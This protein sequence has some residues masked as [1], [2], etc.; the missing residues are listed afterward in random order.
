LAVP[1][2]V[3]DRLAA[4]WD[5]LETRGLNPDDL[6][7]LE[8]PLEGPALV[9]GAGFGIVVEALAASG[10]APVYGLDHSTTMARAARDRR[11]IEVLAGT[12]VALPFRN[13][14]FATVLVP[15]GVLESLR[16]G[17]RLALLDEA[18]RVAAA[19]GALVL[20][21]FRPAES[22]APMGRELG[23]LV[24]Q[25]Q[26]N[27]RMMQLWTHCGARQEQVDR[28]ARWT[29][30]DAGEAAARLDRWYPGLQ[31]LYGFFNKIAARLEELGEEP[32]D[33][34]RRWWAM[35]VAGVAE[36]EI[37][38]LLD[39]ACLVPRADIYEPRRSLWLLDCRDAAS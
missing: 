27:D 24:E 28:V 16:H 12:G 33:F 26:R 35:P 9:I 10:C 2:A 5:L 32:Q 7:R 37:R 30:C 13:D 34:L 21:L 14:C 31:F 6:R 22:G 19:G 38:D 3:W 17:E 15:T 29:G 39:D 11:H 36:Q 4:I 18:K 25:T 20:G 8:G 1:V 23:Y